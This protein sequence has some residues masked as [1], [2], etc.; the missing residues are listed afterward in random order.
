M[1]TW[2]DEI[3]AE[4]LRAQQATKEQN[5]GRLRTCSRRIAGIALTQ[6]YAKNSDFMILLRLAMNDIG[7]PEEVRLAAERLQ[8][9]VRPDFSSA[10]MDPLSDALTVVEFVRRL[11][12][13]TS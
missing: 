9:R 2:N 5:N 3:A 4:L 11:T 8:S 13:T 10:S 6:W 7:V 1:E 12:G